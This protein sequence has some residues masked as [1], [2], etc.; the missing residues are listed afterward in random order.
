LLALC[1]RAMPLF[2]DIFTLILR[3]YFHFRYADF[4]LFIFADCFA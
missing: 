2:A 1:C 4:S 3:D